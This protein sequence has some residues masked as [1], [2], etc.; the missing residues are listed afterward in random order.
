MNMARCVTEKLKK[1]M[2]TKCEYVIFQKWQLLSIYVDTDLLR[3]LAVGIYYPFDYVCVCFFYFISITAGFMVPFCACVC[4]C[5]CVCVGI[6][7]LEVT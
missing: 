4:V 6:V 3:Y 5:V 7:M 2:S 1:R